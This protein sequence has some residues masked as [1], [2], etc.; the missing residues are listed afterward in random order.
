MTEQQEQS[1]D[2]IIKGSET[3]EAE[4]G[5]EA[6]TKEQVAEPAKVEKKTETT[7]EDK[8]SWTKTAV[9]DERRKRQELEA[10]I[11]KLEAKEP[12]AE[13]TKRPDILEDQEGAFRHTE[14]QFANAILQERI[15][16]SRELMIEKHDDY[17]AMEAVFVE[18]AGKNPHLVQEMNKSSNPAKFAYSKAK[19]H[20]DYSDYQKTKDSEEYKAFLEAR[21]TAALEPKEVEET[22]AQKRNKSAVKVPD[23]INATASKSGHTEGEKTLKQLLGR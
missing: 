6:D 2:T 16:L 10:K 22:P 5:Q 4:V 20:N 8:E 17:E 19:E 14:S 21:K 15:N 18:L 12:E 1:L 9:L 3:Q 23:L 11:A 7:A 13:V